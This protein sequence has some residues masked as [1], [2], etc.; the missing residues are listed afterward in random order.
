MFFFKYCCVESGYTIW[1]SQVCHS[2]SYWNTNV[3]QLDIKMKAWILLNT[4]IKCSVYSVSW[5][6]SLQLGYHFCRFIIF[7]LSGRTSTNNY[8]QSENVWL[9]W[10][11]LKCIHFLDMLDFSS[12]LSYSHAR[13]VLN[14]FISSSRL[15]VAFLKDHFW[16]IQKCLA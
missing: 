14:S 10:K 12:S 13:L 7:I 9:L 1:K 2:S 6:C 16:P 3:T 8:K 5:S 11:T 4:M 15:P